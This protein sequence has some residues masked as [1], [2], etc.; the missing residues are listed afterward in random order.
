MNCQ[1]LTPLYVACHF[2][3][4]QGCFGGFIYRECILSAFL[5]IL[6]NFAV[7]NSAVYLRYVYLTTHLVGICTSVLLSTYVPAKF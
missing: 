3:G 2:I 6:C 7:S 1:K 5:Q 4:P